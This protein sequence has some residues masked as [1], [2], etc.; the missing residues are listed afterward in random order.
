MPHSLLRAGPEHC[1]AGVFASYRVIRKAP[2]DEQPATLDR[3]ALVAEVRRLRAGIPSTTTTPD[4]S[5]LAP[6]ELWGLLPEKSDSLPSVPSWP[7][8]LRG[9][10]KYRVV[11]PAVAALRRSAPRG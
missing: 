5:V 7:R 11:L 6:S 1:C 10:L 9:C 8:F 3:D 2:M 4:M